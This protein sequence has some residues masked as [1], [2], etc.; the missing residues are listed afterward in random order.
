MENIPNFEV[1]RTPHYTILKDGK[2]SHY[3]GNR[4]K[5]LDKI[6]ILANGKKLEGIDRFTLNGGRV[7]LKKFKKGEKFANGNQLNWDMY[8]IVD[9]WENKLSE[10]RPALELNEE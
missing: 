9:Q 10:A 5:I 8:L 7:K 3:P 4:L 2:A 6:N 1:E